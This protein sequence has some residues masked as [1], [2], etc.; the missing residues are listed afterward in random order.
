MHS[1]LYRSLGLLLFLVGLGALAL[2]LR[3]LRM[4]ASRKRSVAA[5]QELATKLVRD[6]EEFDGQ[7][8]TIASGLE[9]RRPTAGIDDVLVAVDQI[10]HVSETMR[11]K[12]KDS[13]E[14]IRER[15][16]TLG[17][18]SRTAEA[19]GLDDE[20]EGRRPAL[21]AGAEASARA[22]SS[23]P[24][25]GSPAREGI[26]VVDESR[27]PI[28]GLLNRNAFLE[29][30][31]VRLATLRSKPTTLR[32][33]PAMTCLAMLRIDR[34]GDILSER[35]FRAAETVLLQS[36]EN[37]KGAMRGGDHAARFDRDTF[38]LYLADLSPDDAP[39]AVERLRQSVSQQVEIGNAAPI[40]VTASSSFAPID[41]SAE[42]AQLVASCRGALALA[43]TGEALATG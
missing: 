19:A 20:P 26:L 22:G 13:E 9:E 27:D 33:M 10:S 5:L 7:V 30:L 25:Q 6:V 32:S 24:Q 23:L 16:E 36:A 12:L 1:F 34:F 29:D 3:T 21:I 43:T 2:H 14:K 42:A 40:Q 17:D 18:P 31:K 28:T 15:S 41:S 39:A 4:Q 8:R 38:V 11:T 35:G 37:L